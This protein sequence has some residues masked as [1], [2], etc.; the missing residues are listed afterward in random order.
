MDKT[1]SMYLYVKLNRDLCRLLLSGREQRQCEF[2]FAL[3]EKYISARRGGDTP[4]SWWCHLQ[5]TCVWNQSV[6]SQNMALH[7]C[8]VRKKSQHC[9]AW[10]KY[11]SEQVEHAS[12]NWGGTRCPQYSV[13]KSSSVVRSWFN[14]SCKIYNVTYRTQLATC[15]ILP[16]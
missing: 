2:R 11:W 5:S 12:P 14:R 15:V 4:A 3:V 7:E 10:E 16:V 1:S 8:E 6:T 9:Q 13:K